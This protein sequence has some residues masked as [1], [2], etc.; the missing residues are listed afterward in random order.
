L[1]FYILLSQSHG[2]TTHIFIALLVL[3]A[4]GLGIYGITAWAEY[5]LRLWWRGGTSSR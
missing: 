1:G 2:D 5:L 3:C 4:I